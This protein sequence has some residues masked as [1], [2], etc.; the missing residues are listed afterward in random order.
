MFFFFFSF[1]QYISLSG[2]SENKKKGNFF[3]NETAPQAKRWPITFRCNYSHRLLNFSFSWSKFLYL[4]H[5]VLARIVHT[6]NSGKKTVSN[7]REIKNIDDEGE[8]VIK[9]RFTMLFQFCPEKMFYFLF[10]SFFVIFRCGWIVLRKW[11]VL[12]QRIW[13]RQWIWWTMK[14]DEQQQQQEKIKTLSRVSRW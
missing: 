14:Q 2:Q 5:I 1:I 8:V 12:I 3:L 11:N 13:S 4:F 9:L 7:E 6:V 10:L